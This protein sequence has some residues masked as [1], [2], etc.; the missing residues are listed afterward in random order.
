MRQAVAGQP[1]TLIMA[2]NDLVMMAWS[3]DKAWA[4]A[5][6]DAAQQAPIVDF[7]DLAGNGQL[8]SPKSFSEL[9]RFLKDNGWTALPA[10]QVPTAIK[11]GL[12]VT[13]GWLAQVASSMPVFMFN[14]TGMIQ[15]SN[16]VLA[17]QYPTT[18]E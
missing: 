14:T 2:K 7:K 15:V 6:V 16:D 13:E 3:Y 1:N 12:S 11:V 18:K 9:V 4:F 17:T 5:V 8:V 10:S